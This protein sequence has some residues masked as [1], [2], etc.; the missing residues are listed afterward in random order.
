MEL[1]YIILYGAFCLLVAYAGKHVR[2]GF[3]GLLIL[4]IFLTPLAV[5]ILVFIL[6]PRRS[7]IKKKGK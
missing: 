1:V 5:A 6:E 4:S 2:I 3:F 7:R